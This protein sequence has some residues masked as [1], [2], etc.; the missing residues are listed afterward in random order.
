MPSTLAGERGQASNIRAARVEA[1]SHMAR[2]GLWSTMTTRN[3][4]R[5]TSRGRYL[6]LLLVVG[7]LLAAPAAGATM[8]TT[9]SSGRAASK[10]ASKPMPGVEPTVPTTKQF[11]YTGGV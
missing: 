11:A 5:T 10:A 7:T 3:F 4:R 9:T 2:G 8:T 1:L 6:V